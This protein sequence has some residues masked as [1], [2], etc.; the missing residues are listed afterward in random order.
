MRHHPR[1]S[2]EAAG[3]EASRWRNVAC[4]RELYHLAGDFGRWGDA[5]Y[6]PEKGGYTDTEKW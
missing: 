5:W 3:T 1:R 6:S 2:F 4:C